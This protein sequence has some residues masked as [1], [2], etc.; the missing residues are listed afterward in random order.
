MGK[1]EYAHHKARQ[2]DAHR[3]FGKRS[4]THAEDS[5]PRQLVLS[6]LPPAVEQIH[7]SHHKGGVHHIYTAVHTR[8]VHLEGGERKDGCDEAGL[9][10][11]ALGIEHETADGHQYQRYGRWQ[12]GGVLIHMADEEAKEGDAPVEEW[13]F[14]RDITSVVDRQNPVAMFQHG[15]GNHRFARFS[16]G[17]EICESEEWNHH[18][19]SQ[20]DDEP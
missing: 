14:V 20:D 7:G 5:E 1:H 2:N 8:T 10:V 16:L 15:V 18:H 9:G 13:R 6:F 19:D 11:L 17:I 12:A 4:A 3:T